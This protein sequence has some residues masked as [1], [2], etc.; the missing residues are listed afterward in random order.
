ML[1]I[2]IL[3][4]FTFLMVGISEIPQSLT[5]EEETDPTTGGSYPSD[6]QKAIYTKKVLAS[7][8]FK[9]TMIALGIIVGIML[10]FLGIYLY[11]RFKQSN[12]V[13]VAPYTSESSPSPLYSIADRQPQSSGDEI[14]QALPAQVV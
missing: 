5:K 1:G 6:Q 2:G 9:T 12:A 13:G 7:E 8:G 4:T 10:A 3:S 14:H 11:K